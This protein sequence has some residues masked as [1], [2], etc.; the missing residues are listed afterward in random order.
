VLTIHKIATVAGDVAAAEAKARYYLDPEEAPD[1]GRR[2]NTMWMGSADAL[3][4]LGLKRGAEVTQLEL[5]D[6]LLGLH[7]ETR[8]QVRTLAKLRVPVLAEDGKQLLDEHGKRVREDQEG[9][10]C[11]DFTFAVPKSVSIAWSQAGPELRA[12]IEQAMVESVN[13][14]IEHLVQTRRAV[15][16]RHDVRELGKSYAAA[17]TLQATARQAEDE[18]VPSPHL[19]LHAVVV[20][21]ERHDGMLVAWTPDALKDNAALEGAAVFRAG[22]ANRLVQMG[23]EVRSDTGRKSRF[24]EIV[25]ISQKLIKHFSA[26]TREVEQRVHELELAREAKLRGRARAVVALETR[27]PKGKRITRARMEAVWRT[28][29]EQ[30]G[31][32]AQEHA[33][34]HGAARDEDATREQRLDAA[35][36]AYEQR[37][38]EL[39]PTMPRSLART[40]MYE[41]AGGRLSIGE[42]YEL[43]RELEA[44]GSL[45]ALEEGRATTQSIRALE[46]Q[47]MDTVKA[48]AQQPGLHLSDRAIAIGLEVAN[49]A[50]NKNLK[51]GEARRSL[52]PEQEDAFRRIARGNGWMVLTGRAGTG[53]GP[54]L[55]AVAAA[56]EAD[57]WRVIPCASDNST[58]GRLRKQI[59]AREGY[60]LE[61]VRQ[62]VA[63]ETLTITDKTLVLIDEGSKAGLVDWTD[64]AKWHRAGAVVVPVGHTGQHDAVESPGLFAEMADPTGVVEVIELTKIRRHLDPSDPSRKREHPWLAKY[65]V[66]VDTGTPKSAEAAV[67]LLRDND[68]IEVTDTIAEAIV[69]MVDDWV[70]WRKPY[71][72]EETL[73]LVH[74]SNEDV[75]LVNELAQ[76]RRVEAGE[77]K[78]PSIKAAD[79]E[80]EIYEGDIVVMR[81]AAYDFG[82]PQ[83]GRKRE[84]NLENGQAGVVIGVDAKTE[85]LRVLV[86]EPGYGSRE[87]ELDMRKMREQYLAMVERTG[88]PDRVRMPVLRL[89][90][91]A[92]SFPTQG[93]SIEGIAGLV[94]HWSQGREATYTLDT[95]GIFR[96]TVYLAR[97][98][99]WKSTER[100]ED[101]D[102]AVVHKR[103]A[104][105]I[106]RQMN[107]LASIRTPLDPEAR[108]SVRTPNVTPAPELTKRAPV[109]ERPQLEKPLVVTRE[110]VSVPDPLERVPAALGS[111]RTQVLAA[112]MQ[113]FGPV[114]EDSRTSRLRARL[115]ELDDPVGRLDT[116]AALELRSLQR[117]RAIVTERF[118]EALERAAMLERQA[119]SLSFLR[120]AARR[121]LLDAARVQHEL[122]DKDRAEL[123]LRRRGVHVDDFM[124]RHAGDASL[125]LAIER[126]LAIRAELEVRDRIERTIVD[127]PEHLRAELGDLPV[128]G[129]AVR[130]EW[131]ALARR[132]ERDN[133]EA[134]LA[135]TEGRERPR[136]GEHEQRELDE[137]VD[138]LRAQRGMEPLERVPGIEAAPEAPGPGIEG[139]T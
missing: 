110:D 25:G 49:E 127:P 63:R 104:N 29:C 134:E 14:A 128:R 46:K 84:R 105:L 40:A 58:K 6:A 86:D 22:M 115:A 38:R 135:R 136:R 98:R 70:E 125:A 16:R 103:Y 94:G 23:F 8:M 112:G 18:L 30:M 87:V 43:Q 97:E 57:G 39:G 15:L 4:K 78:G 113:R 107:K 2:A 19:H 91:A 75:D 55:H 50:L 96:H 101:V 99:F 106:Q 28:V 124:D 20:G 81:R 37:M 42:A 77:L 26:R 123:E 85:R 7:V 11:W 34:L 9:V 54:T 120:R 44:E 93:A 116:R 13:E 92:H 130:D 56:C 111:R 64:I 137:R 89:R 67:E 10:N 83:P 47:V 88:Q 17:F 73:L 65:Q 139:A 5:A 74:G 32:G 36:T 132:V 118:G 133:I 24:F 100:F 129:S 41:V 126:E 27:Q 45:L 80:Y 117:D 90:Y 121:D 122:A 1:L 72:L 31:L 53:K 95:R 82:E 71:A 35:R 119:E 66:L 61:Q 60:S 51:P 68:A 52:D 138:R 59:D 76:R 79:R 108:I 114:L 102:V 48:A 69:Q 109:Q 21:V 62:R 131:E 33:D 3:D 12:A